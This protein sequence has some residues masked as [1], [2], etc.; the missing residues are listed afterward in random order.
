MILYR[1]HR[2]V[3]AQLLSLPVEEIDRE[4]TARWNLFHK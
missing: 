4:M 3:V 1:S 2:N